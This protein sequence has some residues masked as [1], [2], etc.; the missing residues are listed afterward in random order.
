MLSERLYRRFAPISGGDTLYGAVLPTEADPIT[1]VFTVDPVTGQPAD[2]YTTSFEVEDWNY[3]MSSSWRNV[4]IADGMAYWAG[5]RENLR[6][7]TVE[8][9]AAT[10]A[11]PDDFTVYEFNMPSSANEVIGFNSTVDA[12]CGYVLV[13]PFFQGGDKSLL[14][15]NTASE[16]AELID[17]GFVVVDAQSIY[18]GITD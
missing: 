7:H 6:T 4:V 15:F 16:T 18:I 11:G 17:T 3:Q 10:L 13:K 9:L 1:G 14:I 2:Y 8:I 5:F 12:A